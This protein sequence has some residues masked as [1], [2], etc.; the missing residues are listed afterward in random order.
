LLVIVIGATAGKMAL[1]EGEGATNQQITSFE[2]LAEGI[3]PQFGTHQLR[4]SEKWLKS[5]ASTATIPILDSGIVARLPVAFPHREDQR[6]ILDSIED[7]VKSYESALTRTECEIGL[8]R[9]YRT[10]LVSDVVT[11]K[12]D[13]REAER[14]I[15]KTTE[16]IPVAID[17]EELEEE[18]VG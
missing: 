11:G 9:E 14:Q 13:V 1:L 4:A 18:T 10:R 16:E 7:E 5:T 8:L 17:D 3:I 12:L 2:L 15:P 6:T